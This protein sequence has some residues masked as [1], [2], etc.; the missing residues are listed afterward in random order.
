MEF[1]CRVNATEVTLWECILVK[2]GSYITTPMLI[3]IIC[4]RLHSKIPY[5][6]PTVLKC[7]SAHQLRKTVKYKI[8]SNFPLARSLKFGWLIQVI[9][10]FDMIIW[11]ITLDTAELKNIPGFNTIH[12]WP[13]EMDNLGK[14]YRICLDCN[15]IW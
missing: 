12:C 5:S 1:K 10:Y 3:V 7:L 13:K 8:S 14:K 2:L 11:N 9:W 4:K 6:F 15:G